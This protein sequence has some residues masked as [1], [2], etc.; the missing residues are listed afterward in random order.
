MKTPEKTEED[1]DD[2]EPKAYA[3]L[4]PQTMTWLLPSA[5]IPIHSDKSF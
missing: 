2:L 1:P 3:G 4:L 5:F